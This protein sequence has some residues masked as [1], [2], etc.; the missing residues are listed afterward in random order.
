MVTLMMV[1]L[2]KMMTTMVTTMM[3][4]SQ[5]YAV[6]AEAPKLVSLLAPQLTALVVQSCKERGPRDASKLWTA[7]ARA[8]R[9][10][11]LVFGFCKG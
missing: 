11:K 3:M 9:L 5:S 6:S 1:T 7:V 4:T 2:A 8:T 10:T